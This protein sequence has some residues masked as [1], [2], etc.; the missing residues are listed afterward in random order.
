MSDLLVMERRK[1]MLFDEATATFSESRTYRYCL[2]RQWRP[3]PAPE[4]AFVMLNPST[5]DAFADDPTIRRCVTF[6]KREG[7]GSLKVVN[8][9]AL[10]SS[11]PAALYDHPDPIGEFNEVVVRHAI[12]TASV[13]VVGWGNHAERLAKYVANQPG[14]SKGLARRAGVKLWCLGTTLGGHPKH[15]LARGRS[16]ISDDQPLMPWPIG[17]DNDE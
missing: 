11:D 4:M 9:F 16:R 12:R 6:A 13:V 10:R 2:T 17:D 1:G 14:W 5:A 15:P 8:L 7:C 3:E